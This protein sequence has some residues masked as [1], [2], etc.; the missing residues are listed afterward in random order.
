MATTNPQ[1]VGSIWNVNSW[2]WENK[3]Y[4]EVAKDMLTKK[5]TN[6]FWSRD[7]INFVF[8]KVDKLKGEAQIN[9]RKGKQILCYEFEME[10]EWSAENEVDSAEGTFK[11]VE[12]N[13]T[14]FDDIEINSIHVKENSKISE[15]SERTAQK[16]ILRKSSSI[17]SSKH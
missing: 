17:R 14:D 4:T 12:L 15:K 8:E 6:Y 2:H 9:I 11:I 13:E 16:N 3:N 7:G 10:I 1:G 5:L